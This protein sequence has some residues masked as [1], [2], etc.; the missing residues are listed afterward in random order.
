MT[1]IVSGAAGGRTLRVPGTGTRPTSER[2]RE[3]L[4]S[5]LEH[6]GAVAG[7]RVLDLYAGSGALGLE[8]ASRGAATV[9]F[10]ESS[11]AAADVCR[12]NAAATRLSRLHVVVERAERFVDRP[13]ASPWD[14][15]LIDP[16]YELA[17]ADLARVL[18]GLAGGGRERDRGAEPRLAEDA[19]VV[20]ERST[21]SPE[22]TWPAA[23]SR[24]EERRYGETVIWFASPD[25]GVGP[26]D[27][28]APGIP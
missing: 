1:R 6:L 18:R 27:P 14:L 4:F 16:P 9:T 8:A 10:V 7:A 26:A 19:I 21:R 5:R 17:E 25:A 15:V 23:M 22:P 20:V 24:T 28:V 12:A 13:A 11:R 3:A 2:V